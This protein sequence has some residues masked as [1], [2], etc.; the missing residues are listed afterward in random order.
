MWRLDEEHCRAIPTTKADSVLLTFTEYNCAPAHDEKLFGILKQNYGRI[1][2]WTQQFGDYDYAK[3]IGGDSMTYLDPSL[4]ALDDCL[5]NGPIDYVGTRLHAGIRA[6]QH[7]R[8]AI[9]V[10]VDNRG[11]EMGRDF[12]IPIIARQQIETDLEGM[13]SAEWPTRVQVDK[14]AIRAWKSQFSAQRAA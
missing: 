9:I 13:I 10:T 8:R 2:F 7:K 5:A 6:L 3:K 14:G 1:F 11:A 4:E 12:Q